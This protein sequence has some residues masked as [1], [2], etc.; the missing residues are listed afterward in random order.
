LADFEVLRN[1][2]G[3]SGSSVHYQ[4]VCE[5]LERGNPAMMTFGGGEVVVWDF[6]GPGTADIVLIDESRLSIVRI[7][8]DASWNEEETEAAII[9]S[10]TAQFDS[11]EVAHLTI[12]SGYLLVLWAPED[13]SEFA[14]PHGAAGVP[15]GL[16]IGDGGAYVRVPSGRYA[17][18]TCE[19]QSENFDVTKLDLQRTNHAA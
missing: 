9:A 2:R 4:A 13:A 19:W 17:I 5:L 15:N 14:T 3:A 7:W 18:T 11:S 12:D 6:G 10:A 8:P 1:W 16:S